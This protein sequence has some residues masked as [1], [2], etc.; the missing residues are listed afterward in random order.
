M[1]GDVT[2]L[3]ERIDDAVAPRLEAVRRGLDSP[4][5]TK[6]Q[7]V[8]IGRLLGGVVVLVFITGL[9]SHLLQQPPGW[10]PLPTHPPTLY[11]WTQGTH[12]LLGTVM[13]P[14]VLAKLWVVYPRLFEW[15]PVKSPAHALERLSVALLV[16]TSVL[17]PLI[18]LANTYQWYPWPFPFR[19]THYAL[20]WVLVGS[21]LVH[22][23]VK[24][25]LIL[26]HWRSGDGSR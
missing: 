6:R 17:Q 23:A 10:L 18:G 26:K 11:Q 3:T 21:M 2:R 19:Q 16:S 7:A 12:V 9:W 15:P 13:L 5:R 1:L 14:L 25:P 8:V 22:L 24:L 20:A 4:A